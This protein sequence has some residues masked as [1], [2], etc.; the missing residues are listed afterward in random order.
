MNA[1]P[2]T[3]KIPI[4]LFLTVCHT[5]LTI[6]ALR[7]WYQIVHYPQVDAFLSSQQLCSGKCIDT[8]R[9]NYYLVTPRGFATLFFVCESLKA[10]SFKIRVSIQRMF[11]ISTCLSYKSIK[12][13]EVELLSNANVV[14]WLTNIL[15]CL[16]NRF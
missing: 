9:R 3:P 11:I 15:L 13:R 14:Q 7:I 8:V 12:E 1:N 6:L 2:F 5:F 4:S 16:V 10:T